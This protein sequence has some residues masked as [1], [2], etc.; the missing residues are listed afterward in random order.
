MRVPER[1]EVLWRLQRRL[2]RRDV[3]GQLLCLLSNL[4]A[5]LAIVLAAFACV[6]SWGFHAF[7]HRA[8]TA[9]TLPP[10][11]EVGDTLVNVV[12]LEPYA[13]SPILVIFMNS[14]CRFC[15][16]SVPF[17]QRIVE[18]RDTSGDVS[19]I[20]ASREQPDSLRS[21]LV[22][23]GLGEADSLTIPEGSAF[24]QYSVPMLLLLNSERTIV[25]IWRGQLSSEA[26]V[27]VLDM[28]FRRTPRPS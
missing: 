20:I 17:Y 5:N 4:A 1:H 23:Q 6:A 26:Q 12:E 9:T 28:R 2:H 14:E 10:S 19:V 8:T 13:G 11:Y 22:A 21:Y 7:R 18:S 3:H 24:K 25:R 15:A 16:E 27:E